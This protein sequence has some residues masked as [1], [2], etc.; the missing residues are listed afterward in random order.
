MHYNHTLS[1]NVLAK[2]K[3]SL[4]PLVTGNW[5]YVTHRV[6]ASVQLLEGCRLFVIC[7]T[8][9]LASLLFARP[10]QKQKVHNIKYTVI[11]GPQWG[12]QLQTIRASQTICAARY[13]WPERYYEISNAHL[14]MLRRLV[15]AVYIYFSK[16]IN[17]RKVLVP[18]SL[19]AGVMFN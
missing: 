4:G 16:K 3:A 18:K 5:A 17:V 7:P 6:P 15:D 11:R 12:I 13:L 14:K 19:Y 10:S 1:N 2:R 8:T 9:R